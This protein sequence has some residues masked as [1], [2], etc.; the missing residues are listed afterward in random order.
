MTDIKFEPGKTLGNGIVNM[1]RQELCELG[2]KLCSRVVAEVGTRA[3]RGGIYPD[4]IC[5]DT[6]G[7]VAIGP[8]KSGD[9]EGQELDFLAPELYWNGKKSQASDVYSLG[10]LLYYA[11][12]KGKLP[13]EAECENP[14]LRRMNGDD[15]P[16]PKA[17]GRRLSE[18]ICKA[19]SFKPES[20]YK[21]LEEMKIMLDNCDKNLYLNGA[22]SAETLFNKNDDDLSDIERIMVDIIEN[23]VDEP[24]EEEVPAAVETPAQPEAT[25]AQPEETVK[26]EAPANDEEEVKVY[27]PVKRKPR[28]PAPKRPAEPRRQPDPRRVPEQRR[29]PE[30]RKQQVPI[31]TEDKNPELEPVVLKQ[32]IQPAVQYG[33]SAEREK[34]IAAKAK[35]SRNRSLVAVLIICAIIVVTAI[36]VNAMLNDFQWKDDNKNSGE[37]DNLPVIDVEISGIGLMPTDSPAIETPAPAESSAT[38]PETAEPGAETPDNE[39]ETPNAEAPAAPKTSRYEIFKD[40]VSWTEARDLCIE[41]GGYLVVINDEEEL[42]KVIDLAEEAGIGR[43][44]IGCHRINETLV[45]E[46]GE[47]VDFYPAP[48]GEGDEPSFVDSYDGAKEDYLMLWDNNGWAY[49]DS[50]ND[51]V[52]DYPQWYKGTIG[53]ICEFTE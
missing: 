8:A 52:A 18:I 36:I 27:E 21:N 29:A 41:K 9:W 2:S 23:G 28:R 13:Y 7:R 45:W 39:T 10:L 35:K 17:A 4:N 37:I 31:L 48:W 1:N 34:K 43:V 30:M 50:R 11:F 6:E 40:D 15:F 26:A 16:A 49:N 12:N 47:M 24:E 44:W 3:Y 25:T 46:N 32:N 22:S 19:T 33:V 51:P 53:Y 14:Q 5:M 20:R 38:E 42:K